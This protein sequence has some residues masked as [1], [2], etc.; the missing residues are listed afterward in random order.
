MSSSDLAQLALHVV[1]ECPGLRLL[2]LMTIGSLDASLGEDNKDFET[3]VRTRDVLQEILRVSPLPDGAAWGRNG[4]LLLSMG[5]SSDY[6]AAI[7]AG[8]DFVRV[9]TSIFGSRPQKQE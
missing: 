6:E 8:S 5:M 9:G 3:L 7:K 2:G 1:R 4:Q